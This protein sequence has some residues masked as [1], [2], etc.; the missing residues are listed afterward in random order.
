MKNNEDQIDKIIIEA[1]SKEEAGYYDKLGEQSIFDM[2][3][4]VFKGKNKGIYLLTMLIS[5][6]QFGVFVY[7]VIVF[8]NSNDIIEMLRYGAIGFLCMLSIVAVKIWYWMQMNTNTLQRELKRIE[9]QLAALIQE[10]QK[11]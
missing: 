9:I 6:L 1:L 11:E 8:F 10:K 7:A 4:G 2:F 3:L 5:I